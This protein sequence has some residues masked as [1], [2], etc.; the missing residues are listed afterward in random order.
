MSVAYYDKIMKK[1]E[2][3]DSKVGFFKFPMRCR[4]EI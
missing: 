2:K 4:Q 1:M 3:N